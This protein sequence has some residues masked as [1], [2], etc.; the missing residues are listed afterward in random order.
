MLMVGSLESRREAFENKSK[1][2]HPEPVH[3]FFFR[4]AEHYKDCEYLIGQGQIWTYSNVSDKSKQLA[5][6]LIDLG[7]KPH[8][9]VAL[10]FPNHPEL[11][12]SKYGVSAASGVAVPLNYRLKKEEFKYLINQSDSSYIITLDVWNNVNFVSILKELCPE[13]FE[14]KN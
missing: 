5:A 7:L 10:I 3:E 14:G 11:I 8:E 6:G 1:E 4:M 13:V 9:H 2:W 12:V